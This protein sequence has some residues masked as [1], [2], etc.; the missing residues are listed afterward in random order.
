MSLY[1]QMRILP[2][3]RVPANAQIEEASSVT[4]AEGHE[5][6][7]IISSSGNSLATLTVVAGSVRSAG[8]SVTPLLLH[9]RLQ[10][11]RENN[12]RMFMQA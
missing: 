8:C 5:R 7:V 12:F 10:L 6:L 4:V 9:V 2:P 11:D 1:T 3:L